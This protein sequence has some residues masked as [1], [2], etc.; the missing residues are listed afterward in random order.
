[1]EESQQGAGAAERWMDRWMDG[2][3][4]SVWTRSTPALRSRTARA[5][6]WSAG[7]ELCASGDGDDGVDESRAGSKLATRLEGV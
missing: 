1:M 3:L 2:E 7:N 5:R 4:S 6:S